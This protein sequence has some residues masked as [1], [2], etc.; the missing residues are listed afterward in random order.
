MLKRKDAALKIFLDKLFTNGVK[1]SIAKIILFGSYAEGSAKRDSDVDVLKLGTDSLARILDACADAQLEA[2]MAT[3]ES[4]EPIIRC[5]D[6]A[7]YIDSLFMYQVLRDG[8]ELYKIGEKEIRKKVETT[9]TSPKNFW[10]QP[11][12]ISI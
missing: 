2:A 11:N 9:K 3:G 1:D 8:K 4:V 5:I 12:K 10:Q 7:R 6:E